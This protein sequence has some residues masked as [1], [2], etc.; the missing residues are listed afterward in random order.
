MLN[1]LLKKSFSR[2]RGGHSPSLRA[3]GKA[4]SFMPHDKLLNLGFKEINNV[5]IAIPA[6]IM[7]GLAC[8]KRS[9]Q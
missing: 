7:L 5:E 6:L 4:I 2:L 8:E 1:S 9:S 3:E